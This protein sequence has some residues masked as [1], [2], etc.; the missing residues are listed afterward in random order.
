MDTQSSPEQTRDQRK[1]RYLPGYGWAANEAIDHHGA[2]QNRG[3]LTTLLALLDA[4]A[5]RVVLEIGTWAGGSAWAWSRVPSVHLIVTVDVE[6][7]PEAAE[8]LASLPCRAAQVVGDSTHPNTVQLVTKALEGYRPDVVVIDAAHDFVHASA[9]FE[10][11]A[12]MAV[13]GGLIVVHDTQG[14]PDND[15]VQVPQLWAHIQRHYRT[16]ELVDLRGG[17]GGT[18]IVWI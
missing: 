6:P 7:R 2:L 14:Y 13:V 15:T 3:E 11:Y 18:G 16:T 5:P 4:H 8:V 1:G 9:D 17:P 10:T 12:T